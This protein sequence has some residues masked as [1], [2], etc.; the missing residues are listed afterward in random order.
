MRCKNTPYLIVILA[1]FI[2]VY[3]LWNV[4]PYA[5]V[6]PDTPRYFIQAQDFQWLTL[7]WRDTLHGP[8]YSFIIAL[9]LLF[10]EPAIALY[11]YNASLFIISMACTYYC[12]TTIF[13]SRV[14]GLLTT[15]SLLLIEIVLMRTFIYSVFAQADAMYAH[16]VYCGVLLIILGYLKSRHTPQYIGFALLGLAAF[17]RQIGLSFVFVWGFILLFQLVKTYRK[18]RNR[19]ACLSLIVCFSLLVLPA[20]AWTMRTVILS[21]GESRGS[22]G[23]HLLWR[24]HEIWINKGIE[25]PRTIEEAE[26]WGNVKLHAN[27]DESS[28]IITKLVADKPEIIRHRFIEP[29]SDNYNLYVALQSLRYFLKD[30]LY[31]ITRDYVFA[32]S[33]STIYKKELFAY[34]DYNQNQYSITPLRNLNPFVLGVIYPHGIPTKVVSNTYLESLFYMVC[35]QNIIM[36]AVHSID[37]FGAISLHLIALTTL[38]LWWRLRQSKDHAWSVPY[39]FTI[40]VL[41][42][43]AFVHTLLSVAVTSFKMRFALPGSMMIHLSLILMTAF[44]IKMLRRL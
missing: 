26:D 42:Y 7:Q 39:L 16:F 3:A 25:R 34:Y 1:A 20:S 35:C 37:Y 17:T 13:H 19:K 11:W 8:L 10:P 6:M 15:L 33:P 27:N 5:V 12:M 2:A 32:F 38:L 29:V 44:L 4:Y 18:T 21:H 9:S 31:V 41:L 22:L 30:Y 43:T 36:S 24:F 28:A 23:F 14:L 40:N